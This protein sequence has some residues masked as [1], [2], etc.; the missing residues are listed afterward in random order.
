MKEELLLS[1]LF[2]HLVA[3]L[4]VGLQGRTEVVGHDGEAVSVGNK[5]GGR[6]ER[7]LLEEPG[8]YVFFRLFRPF[9]QWHVAF[10]GVVCL[11]PAEKTFQAR[12]LFSLQ[13][14]VLHKRQVH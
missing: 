9:V 11:P 10:A 2:P 4:V 13:L 6:H 8:H 1:F 3:L 7:V 12:K 5:L 14:S